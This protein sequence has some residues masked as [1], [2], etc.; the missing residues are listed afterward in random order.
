MTDWT[1][2]QWQGLGHHKIFSQVSK[3][4]TESR[5]LIHVIRAEWIYKK[6]STFSFHS[7]SSQYL[8]SFVKY[9]IIYQ[10]NS[11]LKISSLAY[12]DHFWHFYIMLWKMLWL[13]IFDIIMNRWY[14]SS[15]FRMIHKHIA[16]VT[17]KLNLLASIRCTCLSLYHKMTPIF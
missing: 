14:L 5:D 6:I 15:C 9:P 2:P 3:W 8:R 4:I 1:D 10:C 7:G 12:V 17:V 16:L 11:S 13:N